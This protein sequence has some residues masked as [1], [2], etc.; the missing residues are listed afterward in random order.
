M[1]TDI[2]TLNVSPAPRAGERGW[3]RARHPYEQKWILAALERLAQALR[4]GDAE[5]RVVADWVQRAAPAYGLAV[6]EEAQPA[7]AE[8]QKEAVKQVPKVTAAQWAEVLGALAMRLA[9]L[10]QGAPSP[11]EQAARALGDLAGF[12]DLERA[13]FGLALRRGLYDELGALLRQLADV[14]DTKTPLDRDYDLIALLTGQEAEAVARALT[15]REALLRSVLQTCDDCSC[16]LSVIARL[17]KRLVDYAESGLDGAPEFLG[18]RQTPGLDWADFAHVG[19]DAAHIASVLN[20]ALAAR[21]KGVHV[22]LYGPP[23]TGK[24]ELAKALAGRLGVPL[25]ALGEADEYG[26][27]PSAYE[28]LEELQ[29]AQ[30]LAARGAPCLF[31]LD[32]ASDLFAGERRNDPRSRVFLHRL[33]EEGSVPVIWTTNHLYGFGGSVLRRMAVALEMKVPPV[34]VRARLWAKILDA[35]GIAATPDEAKRLAALAPAAPATVASVVASAAA[36][37]GGL[38]A[39]ERSLRG[40]ARVMSPDSVLRA[41][42]GVPA[43]FD[44]ALS[45]ADRD[46]TALADQ[47]AAVGAGKAVSLLLA[48]PPGTGKSAYARHIAERL[49]LDARVLRASDLLSPYIGETEQQIAAAFHGA[50]ADGVFLVVDEVDS[51]LADRRGAVRSWEVT[52]VNE[53]LTAIDGHPLPFACTTNL[54]ERMD[55]AGLR[56]F[57]FHVTFDY[58]TPA[59]AELA[60]RRFF[61]I[62]PPRSLADVD[63]L[64]PADFAAVKRRAEILGVREDP[65]RLVEELRK[66]RESAVR[67]ARPIGFTR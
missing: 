55:R 22:L 5:T 39:V 15:G 67:D 3:R 19:A 45:Q 37:G 11:I 6:P 2:V 35:H 4:A 12:E 58:L 53:F 66:T 34:P 21:R 61:G 28:R 48:G 33:M 14:N 29:F 23:G 63:H 56:R 46:L 32:E 59:Q 9:H 13:I 27:E 40:I 1:A 57:L 24:T 25:Y 54:V 31:L 49:E 62:A 26:R 52:A 50:A 8:P 64:T 30:M 36:S 44:P 43:G 65:G 20:A 51:F 10:D 47:I 7:M 17:R 38:G 60:F 18:C 16:V 42:A 41:D